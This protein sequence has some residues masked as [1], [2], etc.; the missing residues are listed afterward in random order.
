[1]KRTVHKFLAE[2]GGL[3]KEN[4]RTVE[5]MNLLTLFAFPDSFH[6]KKQAEND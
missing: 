4:V 2:T 1:M 6:R 3:V 5:T